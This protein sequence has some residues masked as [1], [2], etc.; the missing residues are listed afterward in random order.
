M[1]EEDAKLLMKINSS[2]NEKMK[3]F[4]FLASLAWLTIQQSDKT[5][6]NNEK[7]TMEGTI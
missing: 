5:T 1:R 6:I 7:N 3:N 2:R 4:F